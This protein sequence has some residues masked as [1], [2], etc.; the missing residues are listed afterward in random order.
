MSY[1]WLNDITDCL[2]NLGV[3]WRYRQHLLKGEVI[4]TKML[5]PLLIVGVMN[6]RLNTISIISTRL[7]NWCLLIWFG[8]LV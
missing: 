4:G 5:A 7:N 6:F 2:N 8:S 3:E 1:D